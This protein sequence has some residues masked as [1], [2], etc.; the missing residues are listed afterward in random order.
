MDN[1]APCKDCG[2][3]HI[4]CHSNCQTYI[5]WRAAFEE[6]RNETYQRRRIEVALDCTELK[7][8]LNVKHRKHSER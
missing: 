2:N 3:R 6:K 5:K 1:N 8:C 7:R 4:N